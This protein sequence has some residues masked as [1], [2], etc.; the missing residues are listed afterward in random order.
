MSSPPE[1]TPVTYRLANLRE[2]AAVLGVGLVGNQAIVWAFDF[3]LYPFVMWRFGLLHGCVIMMLLSAL[4]C[5]LTLLFYDWSKKDWLGIETL[6]DLRETESQNRFGQL[7]GS[8]MRRSDW[9]ALLVLSIKFDAFI[10]V[11][12]LQHGSYRFNGLSRR[13]WRLFWVSVLISNLYWSFVAFTGITVFRWL[14][15]YLEP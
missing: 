8:L 13:E 2:R 12:Y 6:K 15:G 9:L 14:W 4:M 10:A 11:A 5:Y 1:E 7:L 3:L